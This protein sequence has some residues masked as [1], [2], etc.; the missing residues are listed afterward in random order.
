MQNW[1]ADFFDDEYAA[2]GLANDPP[3]AIDNAADF[4]VKSL[5]LK[6]GEHVFDQCCGIGRMSI[7][8]AK[9]GMRVTGVDI[10]ENYVQSA[11]K[12]AAAEKLPCEFVVG[13]AFNFVAPTKCDA[14][15]NWFTSFSYSPNDAD[16]QRQLRNLYDSLRP[17]GRMVMDYINIA[18]M[19][20]DYRPF[21]VAR[22][23]ATLLQG[24]MV[25]QENTP[26][27]QTG[28]IHSLWTFI[29]PDGTRGEKRFAIRMYMPWDVARM[30]SASGFRVERLLG[31]IDGE[32][33]ERLG[34][35]LIV[36]AAKPG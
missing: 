9:R 27:Y 8:L 13:N 29:R 2:F 33:F 4:I 24:K 12:R 18:R 6:P 14:A 26:D 35:R 15:I 34:K 19:M 30:L 36:V 25:V 1:S 23:T 20:A 16:N 17:G 21:L 32:P 31:S 3:E 10:T 28:K 7:P 5:D 11:R 22:P